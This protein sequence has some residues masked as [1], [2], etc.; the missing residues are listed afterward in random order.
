MADDKYSFDTLIPW[1]TLKAH[2]GRLEKK[3]TARMRGATLHEDMLRCQGE[4]VLLDK[5]YNLPETLKIGEE[6]KEQEQKEQNG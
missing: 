5:L 1:H 2:L 6:L 3:A 4:L